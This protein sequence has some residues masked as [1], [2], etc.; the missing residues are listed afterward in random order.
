MGK[1][2]NGLT[3][4]LPKPSRG[5]ISNSSLAVVNLSSCV[6]LGVMVGSPLSIIFDSVVG[7]DDKRPFVSVVFGTG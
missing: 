5:T 6:S 3:T 2:S 4:G 7:S 1:G